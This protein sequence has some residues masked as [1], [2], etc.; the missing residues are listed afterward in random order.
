MF[1]VFQQGSR[2]DFTEFDLVDHSPTAD[3][4]EEHSFFVIELTTTITTSATT[5]AMSFFGF[6]AA[7][8][9]DQAH[10]SRA[11]GFSAAKDVFAGLGQNDGDYDG[12]V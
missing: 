12:E 8:P 4:Q 1:Q 6:D 5:I 7:M 9:R 3:A 2:F 10:Q 11:P